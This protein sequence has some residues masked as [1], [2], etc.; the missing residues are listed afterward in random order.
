MNTHLCTYIFWCVDHL[1]C[2]RLV[3][4]AHSINMQGSGFYFLNTN[5][6]NAIHTLQRKEEKAF[7]PAS[8]LQQ[9]INVL[10]KRYEHCRQWWKCRENVPKKRK[11]ICQLHYSV[12]ALHKIAG[13][14]LDKPLPIH[15]QAVGCS[16]V[17]E[18]VQMSHE[19]LTKQSGGPESRKTIKKTECMPSEMLLIWYWGNRSQS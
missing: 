10:L 14:S 1:N 5:G 13:F 18:V 8:L 7:S 17:E 11:T 6:C 19:K 16:A 15:N 9:K 2:S 12:S 3:L 4:K